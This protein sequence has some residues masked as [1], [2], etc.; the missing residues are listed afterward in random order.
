MAIFHS[1][2][3]IISRGKGKSAV[4]A[5]AYRAGERIKNEYDGRIHDYTRKS[6]VVYTK[7]ML[8]TNTPVRY[9]NR[10][11]LWNSVEKIEKSANS[12]L[13]RE[14]DIALLVELTLEQNIALARDYIQRTFVDAGMCADLC[15]HDTRTGN[16]HFHVMLVMR[17]INEDGSWGSKQRKEYILD[18]NGNKVYDKK[19][20]Q[21]K[22][23]SV[24]STDW[25]E[26]SKADEW[27]QVWQDMVNAKL[28]RLGF[29][30]YIDRRSY[31][32]QGITDI[33]T[34]H[35]GTQAFR[36]EKR[37]FRT[38]R[39]EYNREVVRINREMA[40][41]KVRIRKSKDW[42]Y[43]QPISD[44]PTMADMMRGMNSGI[45]LKTNWQKIAD[46][47][48]SAHVLIFL[49]NN[50][51]GNMEQ[52]SD[53]VTNTHQRI[54]D[55]G[56][57][58]KAKERRLSKLNEHLAQVDIYNRY[59]GIYKK[60]SQLDS[61]KRDAYKQ[62]HVRE[63]EQYEAAHVYIKAHLNGRT[64]IPERAWRD[65]R[66]SLLTERL[67]LVDEYYDLKDDVKNIETLRR[68]A[69]NL[70]RDVTPERT[71]IKSQ[72]LG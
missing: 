56:K 62:N 31:A 1:H 8:P 64:V 57:V 59:V 37:G 13:A 55:L 10:A 41:L 51:I 33:P 50:G 39:G 71:R 34:I 19:K 24:P 42:I 48:Q 11:V 38:E 69:E 7:I 20:R 70:M 52:F 47:K 30:S 49:Q 58:I 9:L 54:Y 12:Q 43:S 14:L 72:E 6:G 15:V 17:S 32:E 5:A 26:Q 25:N 29:D 67:P 36:M 2:V 65:E 44:A 68:G 21:Y 35:L 23:R 28:K 22:C 18:D 53:K 46:L 3:Q 27:R 4:A 45:K 40:Q 60:Y 63:I 61:R 66:K 16:S